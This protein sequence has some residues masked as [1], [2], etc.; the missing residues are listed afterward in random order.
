MKGDENREESELET[1][2]S[3]EKQ[4]QEEA[5]RPTLCIDFRHSDDYRK[6][7]RERER[8]KEL[9]RKE[10]EKEGKKGRKKKRRLGA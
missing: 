6:S 3:A 10:G 9:Q 8:G 4:K 2:E 1:V 7:E 5:K